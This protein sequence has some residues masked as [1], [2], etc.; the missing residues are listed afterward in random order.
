MLKW[1]I[2]IL[3]AAPCLGSEKDIVDREC[4]G[5]KEVVLKDRSRVDCLTDGVAYEYDYA[6]KWAE[7]LTQAMHYGMWTRR[8]SECVLIYKKPED[9]KYFNR[10]Q[11]L[12]WHYKLPIKLSHVNEWEQ[13]K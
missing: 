2:L 7:C 1:L 4:D 3:L 12:I 10:A 9:F 8:Q 11:N 6:T 5:R 13:P